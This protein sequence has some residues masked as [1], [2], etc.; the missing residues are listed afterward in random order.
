M[1]KHYSRYFNAMSHIYYIGLNYSTRSFFVTENS[2][3]MSH[4]AGHHKGGD[5][6]AHL[7]FNTGGE[8][9]E[10]VLHRADG[11]VQPTGV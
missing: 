7:V 5:M 4:P 9:A 10:F 11:L 8:E 1:L 6:H 3:E 2:L